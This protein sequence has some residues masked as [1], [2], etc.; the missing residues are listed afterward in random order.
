MSTLG[1]VLGS[2]S[3]LEVLRGMADISLR[4]WHASSLMGLS[5]LLLLAIV[6]WGI[7][8]MATTRARGL[9]LSVAGFLGLFALKAHKPD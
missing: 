6:V 2:L 4:W 8:D 5:K 9:I 7:I 1:W 3:P